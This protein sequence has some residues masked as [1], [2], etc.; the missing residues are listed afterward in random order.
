MAAV[1]P[2]W[3]HRFGWR[4]TQRP[5]GQ[6][7]GLHANRAGGGRVHPHRQQERSSFPPASRTVTVPPGATGQDFVGTPLTYTIAGQVS[8][9]SGNPI[10][11]VTVSDGAGHSALT[12][13]AGAYTLTGLAAGTYTLTASKSGYSFAP[14]SR[15]VT[16]PPDATGQD[17]VGTPLTYTVAG[18]VPAAA[19]DRP[20]P[21]FRMAQGHSAPRDATG[22]YTLTGL[23]AG[24]YTLI[25]SKSGYTFSPASRTVTACR[26]LPPGRTSWAQSLTYSV[27]GQV[28]DGGG[29][30][31][32]AATVAD[33]AGHKRAHG[34]AGVYTLTGL[35]GGTIPHRQ[36]ER[37]Q[38]RPSSRTGDRASGCTGQDFV[39]TLHTLW[40]A[41]S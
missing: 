15:T 7:R 18:H 36:Q 9:G 26:R 4:R 33:G 16:V 13:S 14:S 3:S 24:G 37:L 21:P 5:H 41:R 40:P 10:A 17:F 34:H 25:A 27:S 22:A 20:R 30:P 35:A 11:S 23:A 39:G 19:A 31:I 29:Q 28:A 32:A 6:R 1:S 12:D 8:D 2:G 38:F